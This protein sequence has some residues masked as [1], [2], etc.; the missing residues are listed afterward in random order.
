MVDGLKK[1]IEYFRDELAHNQLKY[2]QGYS[3]SA[4]DFNAPRAAI[5]HHNVGRAR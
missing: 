2:G 1:T 3:D 4:A 5:E